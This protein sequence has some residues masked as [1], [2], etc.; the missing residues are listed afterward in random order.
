MGSVTVWINQIMMNTAKILRP[1]I[2][3]LF[4]GVSR[5]L[6]K[7]LLVT[8]EGILTLPGVHELYHTPMLGVRVYAGCGVQ[9]AA[10]YPMLTRPDR[11]QCKSYLGTSCSPNGN[12]DSP[13]EH[14]FI[15]L[16]KDG[17]PKCLNATDMDGIGTGGCDCDQVPYDCD[18]AD[19]TLAVIWDKG[20]A[21]PISRIISITPVGNIMDKEACI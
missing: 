3:N 10:C 2:I 16:D 12:C 15:D 21:A 13:G 11:S 4:R 17:Y 5:R 19:P 14:E 18:D 1:I 8:Q 7:H 6:G 20:N 9:Y